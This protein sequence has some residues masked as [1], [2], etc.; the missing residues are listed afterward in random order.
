MVIL[1]S[2][3][4]TLDTLN[5]NL[6]SIKYITPINAVAHAASVRNPIPHASPIAIVKNILEISF[7]SPGT[8][9][10]LT[11]A[12]TPPNDNALAISEPINIITRDV[13]AGIK[14]SVTAKF[15]ENFLS[16]ELNIYIILIINPS[17]NATPKQATASLADIDVTVVELSIDLNIS[18]YLLLIFLLSYTVCILFRILKMMTDIFFFRLKV[19]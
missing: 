1:S 8:L 2:F 17:I 12:K 9:L 16:L 11:S 6:T 5:P 10:N 14:I 4:D 18:Y 3:S 7:E 19:W 15:A 13:I